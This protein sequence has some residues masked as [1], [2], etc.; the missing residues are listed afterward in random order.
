MLT[1]QEA[2]KH[3]FI[4]WISRFA[5]VLHKQIALHSLICIDDSGDAFRKLWGALNLTK[6]QFLH[7]VALITVL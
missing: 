4:Y 5:L 7:N 2:G 1:R 3:P 6:C